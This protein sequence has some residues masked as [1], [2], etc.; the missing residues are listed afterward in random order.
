MNRQERINQLTLLR[1]RGMSYRDIGQL[2]GISGQRVFQLLKASSL[3]EINSE[4]KRRVTAEV[5]AE[6][7]NK[8]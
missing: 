1:L 2:V 5:L 6:F 3:D 4:I 7:K 8:A